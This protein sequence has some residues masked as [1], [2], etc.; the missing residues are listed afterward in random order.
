MILVRTYHYS[1]LGIGQIDRTLLTETGT[2][3]IDVSG[4]E[5][6]PIPGTI[7]YWEDE[8]LAMSLLHW[9]VIRWWRDLLGHQ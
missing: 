2:Y 1:P 5:T 9:R 7:F 8:H 6:T 4:I 3:R